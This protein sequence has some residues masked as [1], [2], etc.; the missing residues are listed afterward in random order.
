MPLAIAIGKAR[1]IFWGVTQSRSTLAGETQTHKGPVQ[2]P[3]FSLLALTQAVN[4][5]YYR[6]HSPVWSSPQRSLSLP[7]TLSQCREQTGLYLPYLLITSV[8]LSSRPHAPACLPAQ[9]GN[10]GKEVG[11]WAYLS[12]SG[13]SLACVP[14]K[15]LFCLTTSFTWRTCM[16][17]GWTAM[18]HSYMVLFGSWHTWLAVTGPFKHVS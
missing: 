4:L 16:R 3:V 11:V 6:L 10:R 17:H 9:R 2:R 13:V 1:L 14:E 8:R 15:T 12:A 18:A 7:S 5:S